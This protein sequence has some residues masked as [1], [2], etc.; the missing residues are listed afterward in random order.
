M[1][2]E[3]SRE[4]E[5]EEQREGLGYEDLSMNVV[6][7]AMTEEPSES[8][9][10]TGG[11][12]V[13]V[14]AVAVVAV[15]AIL[16]GRYVL[17]PHP[18]HEAEQ[19]LRTRLRTLPVW[20]SGLVMNAR[21]VT[22]DRAR[23]GFGSSIRTTR[24]GEGEVVVTSDQDREKIRSAAREVMEVLVSERPGRDLY[25]DG[26]IGEE[27]VVRAEYRHQSTLMAGGAEGKMDIVVR[28]VGDA[29]GG[30]GDAFDQRERPRTGN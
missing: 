1:A 20:Q 5:E 17:N 11:L 7:A 10:R 9:R 21:Y 27:K 29:K 28:V 13:A 30:M 6:P 26:Y 22:G 14:V 8:V 4:G 24:G 19:R 16:A 23:I 25:L 2:D 3:E 15:V 18:G 12:V